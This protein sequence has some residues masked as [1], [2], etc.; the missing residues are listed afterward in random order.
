MS[1]WSFEKSEL[2]KDLNAEYAKLQRDKTR[3]KKYGARSK[4]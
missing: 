2:R 3:K 4:K 1:D